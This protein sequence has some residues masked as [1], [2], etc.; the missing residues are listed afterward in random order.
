MS[1]NFKDFQAL[2]NALKEVRKTRFY[3]ACQRLMDLSDSAVSIGEMAVSQYSRQYS[4]IQWMKYDESGDPDDVT[5]NPQI[6]STVS[7]L[8]KIQ[9]QA[10]SIRERA[11]AISSGN[12]TQFDLPL[13]TPLPYGW[14]YQ[15]DQ[16]DRALIYP[17]AGYTVGPAT[18][19]YYHASNDQIATISIQEGSPLDVYH[20]W[21]GFAIATSGNLCRYVAW[22]DNSL[23]HRN[24]IVIGPNGWDR[25]HL[26]TQA[27]LDWGESRPSAGEASVA[28]NIV[29]EACQIIA[30]LSTCLARVVSPA[31]QPYIK[32][33]LITGQLPSVTGTVDP[34]NMDTFNAGV[35]NLL[36]SLIALS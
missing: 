7:V 35:N 5:P 28:S 27:R 21:I 13:V 6:S 18:G 3:E 23:A 1:T 15:D 33:Y 34:V 36:D 29:E 19:D 26:A 14:I 8:A 17:P 10:K 16:P 12:Q 32:E 25:F 20:L 4:Q 30:R 9:S 2:N 22:A 31:S 24:I 11:G